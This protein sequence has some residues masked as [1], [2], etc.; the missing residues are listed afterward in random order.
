[1]EDD[2]SMIFKLQKQGGGEAHGNETSIISMDESG[3]FRNTNLSKTVESRAMDRSLNDLEYVIGQMMG[4]LSQLDVDQSEADDLRKKIVA[5][6]RKNGHHV[7]LGNVV[8][9]AREFDDK[10]SR[11]LSCPN[12]CWFNS[13]VCF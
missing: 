11:C 2:Q 8:A 9:L 13:S 3:D 12:I 10:A 5:F 4:V 6:L 1:V 7:N